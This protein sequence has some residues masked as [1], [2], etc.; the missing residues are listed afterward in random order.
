M[1]PAEESE[2]VHRMSN[3]YSWGETITRAARGEL[4]LASE[5][6]MFKVV[7][8]ALEMTSWM[9]CEDAKAE[10]V[11]ALAQRDWAW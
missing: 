5:E 1:G 7:I 3:I 4:G 6:E 11:G 2:A 8:D 10:I 9:L